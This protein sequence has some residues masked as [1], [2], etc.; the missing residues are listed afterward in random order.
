MLDVEG[1]SSMEEEEV[2]NI[3]EKIDD[4][5][6]EDIRQFIAK[7]GGGL[8]A[9][10]EQWFKDKGACITDYGGNTNAWLIGA[11]CT[12]VQAW[13]WYRELWETY[14]KARKAGLVKFS[15]K[16]WSIGFPEDHEPLGEGD[17][18]KSGV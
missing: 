10:I 17:Q 5:T 7:H 3:E 8:F 1:R 15:L 13:A 11:H 14:D 4:F 12:S 16:P 9:S 18:W 6:P 2:Q